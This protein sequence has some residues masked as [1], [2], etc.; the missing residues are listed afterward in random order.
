[1]K[2]I[3]LGLILIMTGVQSQAQRAFDLQ[4]HRGCRGL[5]PE[6][7]IAAFIR[8]VDLGVTTL[9]MDVVITK[10]GQVLVSHDPYMNSAFC[11]DSTG[12][13]IAKERQKDYRIY[14]M[15]F[16]Q[17]KKFDCGTLPH[18]DFPEQKKMKAT[19]P[20]LK[21][22]IAAVEAYIKVHKLPWVQYNIE[23]KCSRDGDEVFHPKPEPFTDLLMSVIKEKGISSRC[24][25]QSFDMRTLQYLHVKYPEM[26][27]ALLIANPKSFKGNL[28]TLGFKPDIYSPNQIL[29]SR[30]LVERAHKA[31]VKLIP[32][33][34]N[35]EKDILKMRL[36]GVDGLITD[37]PDRV[38]K[39]K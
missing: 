13:P 36:L 6:N 10:D 4:G 7:T 28:K 26:K 17:V 5:M 34:I 1:M 18:P 29:V 22:A 16:E 2:T 11:L 39:G 33:T 15:N 8:A 21:D 25:I 35:S 20:L 12:Q 30:S 3:L 14:G 23:T 27:T 31:G 37:Y 24:I 19:K 32:W 9:E 38:K